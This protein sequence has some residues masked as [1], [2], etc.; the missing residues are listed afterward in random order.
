M[1]D[2]GLQAPSMKIIDT[3]I[4][5]LENNGFELTRE[6]SFTEYL[7][8]K[9]HK[10]DDESIMMTQEG[11]IQK[12][13]EATGMEECNPN[14]T[15]TTREALGINPEGEPMEDS[16]NYRSIIGMMLYLTT[17]TRPDISYAVSQVA[18]FSHCP[19]KSHASAVKTIIRYLAGTKDKGV[20]YKRPDE[21]ILDC[22]VDADFSGLYGREPSESSTSAKS[23]TG[24]IIS[25]GGCYIMS[26]SQLQSTIALS[27]SESEYGALSQSMRAV[28][29][30]RETVL[31][32]ISAVDMT[33]KEGLFPFG[34][35]EK[36]LLFRTIIHE[37]NSTALKL[38]NSQKVTSRTK[39][40]N[41]KF[42]FFWSHINDKAKNIQVV[43]V[44]TKFQQAD[45]LTKGLT[46]ELFE[47]CRRL[48]QG[49]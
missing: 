45:Y 8:I 14:L 21:L 25:I 36:L 29:P 27:T 4:N 6:G 16:W 26:K 1:D 31:E 11:L 35:R 48:N 20:I 43:K 7:G 30:L 42:H 18:R 37:D 2:L 15:P 49:W 24:Y 44:D 22:F 12:I 13:I 9:Y 17:N 19:K 5:N 39:H 34:Q 3:L 32:I 10:N 40:W 46:R 28:L 47:N 23:R 33:D 38:A 41:V